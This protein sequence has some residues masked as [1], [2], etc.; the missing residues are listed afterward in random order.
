VYQK[1]EDCFLLLER[2]IFAGKG[3][4]FLQGE[5]IELG[6]TEWDDP[7]KE[8]FKELIIQTNKKRA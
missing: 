5:D 6:F 8:A 4:L 1:I 3:F 7:L 2:R